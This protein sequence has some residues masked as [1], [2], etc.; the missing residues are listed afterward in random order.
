M[1]NRVYHPGIKYGH[2]IETGIG[3]REEKPRSLIL[4]DSSG[5]E[6]EILLRCI[7]SQRVFSKHLVMGI[8]TGMSSV[9]TCIRCKAP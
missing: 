9:Q 5:A 2:L 3:H 7:H 1:E 6:K 4:N 8:F